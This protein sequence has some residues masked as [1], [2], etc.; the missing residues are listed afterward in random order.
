MAQIDL[1]PATPGNTTGLHIHVPSGQSANV[2]DNPSDFPAPSKSG[3]ATV[4]KIS[5][6]QGS[7]VRFANPS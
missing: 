7:Q 3:V 4:A 1:S 5:G 6:T 2:A